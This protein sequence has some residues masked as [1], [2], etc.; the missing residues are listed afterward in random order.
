MAT[1]S[2]ILA[3]RI[4]TDREAQRAT[5]HGVAES[6]M[7]EQQST[8]QHIKAY[9]YNS[10]I[11]RI[12]TYNSSTYKFS[13]LQ[14]CKNNIH[15]VKNILQ[16]FYFDLSPKLVTHGEILSHDVTAPHQPP[17][18]MV[19]YYTVYDHFYQRNHF[20]FSLLVQHSINYMRQSTFHYKICFALYFLPICKLAQVSENNK[21]RLG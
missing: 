2:S 6:D 21:G 5:V 3:W 20:L 18:V 1:H 7:T 8:A 19:K 4:P 14:R 11:Q 17:I 16:I 10:F 12:L 9:A 13:T 15:S